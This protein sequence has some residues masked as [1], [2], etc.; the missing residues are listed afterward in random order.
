VVRVGDGRIIGG[1]EGKGV[2]SVYWKREK[3]EVNG[4]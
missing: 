3:S 1:V 2:A 4:K